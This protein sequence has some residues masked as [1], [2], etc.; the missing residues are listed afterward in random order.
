MFSNWIQDGS[1]NDLK[2][3]H[4]E[5]SYWSY[6]EK[7]SGKSPDALKRGNLKK[8]SSMVSMESFLKLPSIAER[9]RNMKA[10]Q[11]VNN[12]FSPRNSHKNH[13]KTVTIVD[14]P[15]VD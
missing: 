9:D 5:I 12:V 3:P 1:A 10:L 15:K 4:D 14:A 13:R 2:R 7:K 11:V 6:L 8:K